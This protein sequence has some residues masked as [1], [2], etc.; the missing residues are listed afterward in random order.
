VTLNPA[1]ARLH[2]N[3][4]Q[5]LRARGDPKGAVAAYGR[6]LALHPQL[7]AAHTNLGNALRDLKDLDGALAACRRAVELDPKLAIAHTNLGVVLHDRGD[8][9]GA[10][11]A[12]RR[13][14]EL[15]PANAQAYANLGG[16]L[17]AQGRWEEGARECRKAVEIDPQYGIGHGALGQ[18]LLRLG[19]FAEARGALR[20]SRELL[21]EG[22]RRR[23][24]VAG[25]LQSCERLLSRD[26][27]LAALLDGGA[28]PAGAGERLELAG[29]CRRHERYSTATRFYA[30]ALAGQPG[31]AEDPRRGHRYQAACA[32]ALAAA[33]RGK[34]AGKPDEKEQAR[35]RRLALGWLRADLEAWAKLL[36]RD[37]RQAH[38]AVRAALARWRG[39]AGLAGVRDKEALSEL[40]EAERRQ[41]QQLWADV[42]A[43]LRRAAG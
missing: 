18:A 39:A 28:E 32:A 2:L 12:Y 5:V 8:A 42:A 20:R 15:D 6:A 24:V 34:D 36:D 9:E 43:L 29:F 14:V 22:D 41:W 27:A 13:A 4:G 25:L 26:A 35:L 21:P 33:G 16:A 31:S 17:G 10:S 11:A 23:E 40:A 37:A 1:D 3:L 30:E 7:A 38:T 19:R